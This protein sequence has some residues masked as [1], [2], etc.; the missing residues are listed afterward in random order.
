MPLF[1]SLFPLYFLILSVIVA[2]FPKVS[3]VLLTM[4]LGTHSESGTILSP[5][6]SLGFQA[7]DD[8]MQVNWNSDW[9]G[10]ALNLKVSIT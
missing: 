6:I 3:F 10:S 8:P 9:A 5:A 4:D 2:Q 1:L 7:E